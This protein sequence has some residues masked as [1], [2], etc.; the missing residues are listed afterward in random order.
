[1]AL[2]VAMGPSNSPSTPKVLST[3]LHGVSPL[4]TKTVVAHSP[5][6]S[7]VPRYRA[8]EK[9]P[10]VISSC[11]PPPND[12]RGCTRGWL[13]ASCATAMPLA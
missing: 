13:D 12:P 3:M 8:A 10:P 4:H 2:M 1:M 7:G 11:T 6:P 5:S 9:P